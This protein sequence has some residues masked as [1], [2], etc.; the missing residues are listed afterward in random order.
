[1]KAPSYSRLAARTSWV[2]WLMVILSGCAQSGISSSGS[3]SDW[4]ES[5]VLKQ[6]IAAQLSNP[7][8]L[9]SGHGDIALPAPAFVAA[10]E[11]WSAKQ[12]TSSSGASSTTFGNAGVA[13][14]P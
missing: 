7:A 3:G 1:M 9:V 2:M 12:S 10:T 6:D 13:G 11:A 14:T 4:K 5:N 8:D